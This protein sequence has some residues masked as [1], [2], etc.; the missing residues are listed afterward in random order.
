MTKP[1]GRP[2]GRHKGSKNKAT[3]EREERAR[4]ELA[5]REQELEDGVE[6]IAS[7]RRAGNKLAK[8]VLEDLMQLGMGLT[9]SYQNLAGLTPQQLMAQG[10]QTTVN[11]AM[12]EKFWRAAAFTKDCAKELAN[13]QSPKLKAQ[14]PMT[15]P[16]TPAT[17]LLPAP[18]PGSTNVQY[19]LE[20]TYRRMLKTVNG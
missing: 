15:L 19:F 16:Q 9:A 10:Q 8:E 2:R 11:D 6:R 13:Y 18:A 20:H 14:V 1:T 4:R 3:I 7:A 12:E 5:A 17:P